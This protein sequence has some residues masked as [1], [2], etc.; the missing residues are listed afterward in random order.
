MA[1]IF[2]V[3]NFRKID[4][5]NDEDYLIIQQLAHDDLIRPAPI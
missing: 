1:F 5:S 3:F 2:T 4:E